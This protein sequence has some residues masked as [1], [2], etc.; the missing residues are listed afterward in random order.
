[1]AFGLGSGL[2]G[3]SSSTQ[4]ASWKDIQ[5]DIQLPNGPS[6]SVSSLSFSPVADFLAVGSWDSSVR[7]YE[8]SNSPSG[9]AS[10]NHEGPVLDVCWSK[11]GSKVLSGGTDKAG[12]MYDVQSG[13]MTQVAA[14]EG[15]VKAVRWVDQQNGLL[16][17]GSWDKT[18]KVKNT[19][20]PPG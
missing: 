15:A 19:S 11:D 2:G 18:I 1:M 13:K 7:I 9:K 14:H 4:A 16:A 12:R 8:A 5:S 6:D 17:T 20:T 3:S 10:Y